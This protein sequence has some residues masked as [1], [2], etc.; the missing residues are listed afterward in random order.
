MKIVIMISVMLFMLN[1][2]GKSAEITKK[3]LG[4][5]LSDSAYTEDCSD[6]ALCITRQE[7]YEHGRI[8]YRTNGD[9]AAIILEEPDKKPVP[10][11][12]DEQ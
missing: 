5:K 12:K 7:N 4:A 6:D 10:L 2:V 9:T 8:M 11:D 1:T 3:E